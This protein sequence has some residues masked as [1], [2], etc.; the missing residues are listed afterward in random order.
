[1]KRFFRGFWLFAML[2]LFSHPALAAEAKGDW[3]GALEVNGTKLRIAVHIKPGEDG[4]LQGTL[5]S[6]DQGG[7]G[8]PIAEIAATSS[9]LKFAVPSV[10]GRFEGLWDEAGKAWAGQWS[11]GGPSLPLVLTAAPPEAPPPPLPAN[12][13]IPSTGEIEKLLAQRIADRPGGGIVAGVIEPAG[14]RVVG[15]GPAAGP[16]FDG[17]TLF[18]IGSISKVFTAL[19]LADMVER[20]EVAL[21]DPAE[22]FLPAGSKMPERA[23][24]KI[25]LL[26]LATHRSGLPRLPDNMAMADPDDPYA[27]YSEAQL[28]DFLASHQLGRDIG[29]QYE[30]SNFGMGL[31]G[32][33]L[34][35]RAGS[36]YE[37]LLRTRITGPLG[38][39]DTAV[40]LSAQQLGRFATGHDMFMRP[41]KPWTL[42]LLAGAGGVRSTANDMLRF[43]QGF[44]EPGNGPLAPAMKAML[45][46]RWP[47]ADPRF[48]TALGWV[49][50]K[51]PAGDIVMH[52]GGTGG[53]R[54][55]LAFDPAKKRGA[56][57]L[58]NCA[59]EPAVNDLAIHML[60]GSPV[61]PNRP[62]P[63]AP[64]PAQKRTAIT[65]PAAE[66]D[67]LAGRYSFPN[68]MEMLV[69]RDGEGLI[70]QLTGQPKFPIFAEAPLR[71]FWRVV[72]AQL[73]FV[74]G[75]AGKITGATLVQAGM[76]LNGT[77]VP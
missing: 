57:L 51:S 63:P 53:Y 24:R 27:D 54:S 40:M 38:M 75:E 22:K 37:T 18:E 25:T 5:D 12:W 11:Q 16:A 14:R 6:L 13:S 67:R 8:I 2:G 77:R 33:L 41:A 72:D 21:D 9:T 52:D 35:R 42:D 44:V 76:R 48:D 71:F 59:A 4:T 3:I 60:V 65:L 68:G 39:K 55:S 45:A 30:Y 7:F 19:L 28:L 10:G 17:D 20:G 43:V 64:P 46:R 61:A 73:E 56:V 15:Q 34:A 32:Y 70:A 62:V 50:A 26:D 1:M 36:D 69:E 66:L 23:G 47:A 49:I 58:T 74:A 29:S 31:L